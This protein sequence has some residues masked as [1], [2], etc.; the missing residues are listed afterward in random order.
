MPLIFSDPQVRT[1]QLRLRTVCSARA[2]DLNAAAAVKEIEDFLGAGSG[3]LGIAGIVVRS[4][5]KSG[6]ESGLVLGQG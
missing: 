1:P 6:D 4:L 2:V 3:S 5:R